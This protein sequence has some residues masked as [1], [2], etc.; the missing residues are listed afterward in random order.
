[1]S[2]RFCFAT[3]AVILWL[4]TPVL[5]QKD[6]Q[7]EY[8]PRSKPGVGQKFLARFAGDW[9]VAKAFYPPRGGAAVHVKGTCRQRMINDGRFLRSEFVFQTGAEKTT[10]LGLIGFDPKTGLFSTVWCDSRSTRLSLRQSRE[11]FNGK[12]ILL[13]SRSLDGGAK[14]A[15][16]SHTITVLENHDRKI[17]HRQYATGRDGKARLMMELILT[18]KPAAADRQ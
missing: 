9:D 4:A 10:G 18:R 12:E 3:I 11:P 13:Y 17:I 15:W 16:R 14:P 8:E 1:M 2:R 5:A 7:S 6:A